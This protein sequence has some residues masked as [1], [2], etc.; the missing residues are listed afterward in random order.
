MHTPSLTRLFFNIYIIVNSPYSEEEM[1]CIIDTPDF[2]PGKKYP[3]RIDETE[4]L[5]DIF[6]L[7]SYLNFRPVILEKFPINY[8]VIGII[9]PYSNIVC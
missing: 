5:L 2:D 1:E 9:K 8:R 7:C 6:N 4:Y 3:I